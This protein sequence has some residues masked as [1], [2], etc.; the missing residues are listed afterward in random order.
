MAGS[1]RN[2][3]GKENRTHTPKKAPGSK[4][5]QGKSVG[6][7]LVVVFFGWLDREIGFTCLPRPFDLYLDLAY[8]IDPIPT[9][10]V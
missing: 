1:R 3:G 9:S 4:K 2:V 10:Y 8:L 6:D 5:R 7:R